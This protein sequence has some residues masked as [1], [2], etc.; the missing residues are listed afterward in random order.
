MPYIRVDVDS[1]DEML[2]ELGPGVIS[3]ER[4][5]GEFEYEAST[6]TFDFKKLGK[7]SRVIY[8]AMRAAGATAFR[9]R[10]D[11]GYDEGFAHP[12]AVTFGGGDVRPAARVIEELT[13]PD[14]VERLK[15]SADPDRAAP[16]GKAVTYAFDEFAHE[17]ASK[18]LGAG[19]GTGEYELYGAFTAD[20]TSGEITDDPEAKRP[21]DVE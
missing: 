21:P 19:Y 4:P 5:S 7:A 8:E 6:A 11:G 10:Y 12:D 3:G 1:Y 13:G 20:L 2:E 17:L 14:L 16:P 9:V 15:R 18:L